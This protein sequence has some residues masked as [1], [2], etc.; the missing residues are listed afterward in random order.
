MY[1]STF[2][3]PQNLMVVSAELHALASLPHRKESA[4]AIG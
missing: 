1:R 3:L 4:V 2:S